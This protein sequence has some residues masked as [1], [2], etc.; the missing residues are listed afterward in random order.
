[1]LGS[2]GSSRP[3]AV[4]AFQTGEANAVHDLRLGTLEA[5]RVSL[6]ESL[7][8]GGVSRQHGEHQAFTIVGRAPQLL[9]LLDDACAVGLV[10]AF[11][12]VRQVEI[13]T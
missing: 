11:Q 3:A 8:H 10:A 4:S 13:E 6:L 5:G 7:P 1:M 9:E 12:V 2:F